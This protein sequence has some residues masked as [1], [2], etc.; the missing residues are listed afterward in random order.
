MCFGSQDNDPTQQPIKITQSSEAQ[1]DGSTPSKRKEQ[2]KHSYTDLHDS[3][4]RDVHQIE[5]ANL[6]SKKSEP[7]SSAPLT[8]KQLRDKYNNKPNNVAVFA[9]NNYDIF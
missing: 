8:R 1:S 6:D 4:T 3:E 2:K 9:G 5:K 7:T